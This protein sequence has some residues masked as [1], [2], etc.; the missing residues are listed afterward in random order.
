MWIDALSISPVA[1]PAASDLCA[2]VD[3]GD[4]LLV[5]YQHPLGWGWSSEVHVHGIGHRML[6]SGARNEVSE[7]TTTLTLDDAAYWQTAGDTW[8]YRRGTPANG[9]HPP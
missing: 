2:T 9:P 7:W 5:A 8:D 6:P 4:R 3:F 1:D